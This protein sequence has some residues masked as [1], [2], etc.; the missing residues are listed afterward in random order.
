[1]GDGDGGNWI[2][3]MGIGGT[4]VVVEWATTEVGGG[5]GGRP[6]YPGRPVVG[7]GG[8]GSD[9]PALGA[10]ANGSVVPPRGRN[11]EGAAPAAR[12]KGGD[13]GR[14]PMATEARLSTSDRRAENWP[15]CRWSP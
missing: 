7:K 3:V 2:C 9:G 14:P 11:G 1:M 8:G 12:A 4:V 5:I 15:I 13:D 10:A 6:P